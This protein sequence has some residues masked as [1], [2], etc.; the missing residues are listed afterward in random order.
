MLSKT[1]LATLLATFTLAAP[2]VDVEERAYTYT[3]AYNWGSGTSTTGTSYG[4]TAG[5]ACTK[6]EVVSARGTSET[7]TS[8]YGNTATV[9]GILSAV[10]GGAHYEV[11]YP[12]D[13]NF[14]TGPSIGAADL[15]QHVNGRISSCPNMKFVLIGYSQGAMVTV[16]AENNSQ[17]PRSSVVA[18][19]LYGNPYWLPG[20]PEDAGTATSGR[21]D[22]SATGTKTPATYQSI[23]KDYC[24][25]GDIICT[26][27]GSIYAHLA[28]S[29]SPQQTQAIAYAT[30]Q[31][32]AAGI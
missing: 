17:L 11:V 23:T 12:A 14:A 5:T 10:A 4:T 15:I 20:R 32:R 18:T 29:G 26:S 19:I 7:Q 25:T 1:V 9:N 27:T 21:G 8:P 31:L 24:N 3:P 30:S 13:N 28:Y 22:A 16:T 6:Y 2:V